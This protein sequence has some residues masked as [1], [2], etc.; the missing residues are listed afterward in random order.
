MYVLRLI[1]AVLHEREG[2]SVSDA[3]LDLRPGEIGVLAP[4]V[5]LLLVLSAWPAGITDRSFPDE[6][7]AR[8]VETQFGSASGWTNYAP[9]AER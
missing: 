1:S 8:T 5:A 4:L 2:S 7:A 3:A 9:L 6:G